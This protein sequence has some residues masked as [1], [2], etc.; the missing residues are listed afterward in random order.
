MPLTKTQKSKL[1]NK[2]TPND[3]TIKQSWLHSKLHFQLP[4]HNRKS[5]TT[6]QDKPVNVPQDLLQSHSPTQNSKSLPPPA[7]TYSKE[8]ANYYNKI[9][10][11]TR[12]TYGYPLPGK[13]RPEFKI[14]RKPLEKRGNRLDE[15]IKV[16]IGKNLNCSRPQT[17]IDTPP[18]ANLPKPHL[19]AKVFSSQSNI[20]PRPPWTPSKMNSEVHMR[21]F[22][23]FDHFP[24]R[25]GHQK[26]REILKE[27]KHARPQTVIASEVQR[28]KSSAILVYHKPSRRSSP[29]VPQE[30]SHSRPGSSRTHSLV[31]QSK[32]QQDLELKML[33][34]QYYHLAAHGR[35]MAKH[36]SSAT[37]LGSEARSH[38]SRAATTSQSL[39]RTLRVE[40]RPLP[41]TPPPHQ[42]SEI[43]V[44]S[45]ARSYKPQTQTIP[46][47]SEHTSQLEPISLP[48]IPIPH[49]T[50][51]IPTHLSV[52]PYRSRAPVNP[53]SSENISQSETRY[54]PRVPIYPRSPENI[55]HSE[56]RP[57][58][59]KPIP[60]QPSARPHRPRTPTIPK[61]SENTNQ[62]EARPSPPVLNTHPR[63]RERPLKL[64][65]PRSPAP[66]SGK[67]TKKKRRWWKI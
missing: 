15:D 1:A 20:Y 26:S 30:A 50:S 21:E 49:Q 17:I 37:S 52:K 38:K 9:S 34:E 41:P 46:K 12:K 8:Q 44:R 39:E 43:S 35:Q 16:K 58:P 25:N 67:E 40:A 19:R 61:P 66:F 14:P 28:Y 56:A 23:D 2:P 22:S 54:P 10:P 5:S 29:K 47:P 6:L 53:I 33:E 59:R 18:Q 48:R 63:R 65:K 4:E 27:T 32:R 42:L 24:P 45:S 51:T 62:L 55:S 3:K 57:Q 11:E 7:L 36:Q 64:S 60:H 13:S 31:E